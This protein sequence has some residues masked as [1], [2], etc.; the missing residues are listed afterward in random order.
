MTARGVVVL[1]GP[2][3]RAG[4]QAVAELRLRSGVALPSA[5]G[6][7]LLD[8]GAVDASGGSSATPRLCEAARRLGFFT[9]AVI[10][11]DPDDEDVR[12]AN[13]QAADAVVRLPD[14]MAIE[15][16]LLDGVADEE[17]RKALRRLDTQLQGDPDDVRGRDLERLARTTL[18]SSG[19]LHA[20]FVDLL[21]RPHVPA[22][23]ARILDQTTRCVVE[24]DTGLHQL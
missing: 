8:A 14:G 2:H 23:A 19:G 13:L 17:I 10:D 24:R 12:D 21:P 11:G 18:K 1:E 15:R 6:V 3:D 20:Q 5:H 4:L 7:A 16:A 9:V 22:V